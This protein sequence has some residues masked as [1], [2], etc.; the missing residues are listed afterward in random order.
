MPKTDD[1]DRLKE[2]ETQLKGKTLLVYWFLL[3]SGDPV[4]VRGIQR[5]LS[6]SSPS[7]A[8]HHLDKLKELGIVNQDAYD[9]YYLSEKVEVGVLQVFSKVGRFMLPRY[10]FYAT[11]FTTLLILYLIFS[12]SA[13]NIFAISFGIVGCLIFWYESLR[14]WRRR[15]I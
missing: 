13:L 5:G 12:F 1:K 7:V 6:M 4:G 15:P 3:R 11:F 9:R 10:S 8:A 2:I 14:I